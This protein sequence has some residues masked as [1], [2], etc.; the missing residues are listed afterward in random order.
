MEI[1]DALTVVP[2]AIPLFLNLVNDRVWP[3]SDAVHEVVDR[4]SVLVPARNEAANIEACVTAALAV[5]PP[6]HE[7]I[8]LDDGSTDATPDIL[9]RLAQTDARLTVLQGAPLPPGWVGKPHACHQ[10]GQ[11]ATGDVLLFVDADTTLTTDATQRLAALFARYRPKVITAFPR[12][13]TVSLVEQAIVPLLA[14]TFT[15]WLP[16]DLVWQ[17]VNPR[18]L[19][20]NGQVIAFR[21]EAYDAIGG[22]AAVAGEIVDD[23]AV[24]RRAKQADQRV[25]FADGQHLASCRMYASASDV[26][27]GFSKNFYE[28]LGARPLV[29]LGVLTAYLLAF[30][31]PYVRLG[32][33]LALWGTIGWAA[34]L[35]VAFNLGARTILARRLHHSPWSVLV[36]P[37]AVCVLVAIALNSAL[38][39]RRGTIAWRGRVYGDRT[40]RK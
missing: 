11:A 14:L 39:S 22:Y 34:A 38:W 16:L 4:I 10:L 19:V 24:C 15:S 17:H 5:Q 21:R 25:V 36:H 26:W 33:D 30:V 23:V 37:L 32:V 12:Q 27:S 18:F 3:R 9:A 7:V 28:G 2:A 1:I 8:V 20:V 40:T 13:H 35:G 6:V 31:G 29:L